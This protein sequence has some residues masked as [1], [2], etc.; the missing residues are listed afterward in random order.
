MTVTRALSFLLVLHQLSSASAESKIPAAWADI[1]VQEQRPAAYVQLLVHNRAGVNVSLQS[2][3]EEHVV[4]PGGNTTIALSG[5]SGFW[6]VPQ[7]VQWD[8]HSGPFDLFYIAANLTGPELVTGVGFGFAPE[9]AEEEEAQGGNHENVSA[10]DENSSESDVSAQALGKVAGV[11]LATL[12]TGDAVS[13][14]V[15]CRQNHCGESVDLEELPE[16][17]RLSIV[18]PQANVLSFW[19]GGGHVVHHHHHHHW[20]GRGWGRRGRGWHGRCQWWCRGRCFC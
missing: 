18:G 3:E 5:L 17:L 2:C 8:C 4:S 14:G 19:Y 20:G 15:R 11:E 1:R 10:S 6:V 9:E 7:D 16:V 13:P 12:T